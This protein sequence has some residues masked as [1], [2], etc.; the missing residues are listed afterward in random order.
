MTTNLLATIDLTSAGT[1][2]GSWAVVPGMTATVDIA[3]IDSVVVMSAQI[4]MLSESADTTGDFRFTVDGSPVGPVVPAFTDNIGGRV[5]GNTLEHAVTGLSAGSHTIAVQFIN[6]KGTAELDTARTR[7]MQVYEF[8]EGA[9]IIL[10]I[11]TTAASGNTPASWTNVAGMSGAPTIAT[12]SMLLL[13][14]NL[15]SL[16]NS[17]SANFSFAI[18]GVQVGPEQIMNAQT[19]DELN[20]LSMLWAKTGVAS[21]ART[22]SLQWK[23]NGNPFPDRALRVTGVRTIQAIQFTGADWLLLADITLTSAEQD[24]ATWGV[25]AGMTTTQ[26]PDSADSALLAIVNTSIQAFD[27]DDAT[28][29]RLAMGGSLVGA[30]LIAWDDGD[31]VTRGQLLT[32]METGHTGATVVEVQWQAVLSAANTDTFR[33][34]TTQL[35]EFKKIVAGGGAYGLGSGI[36]AAYRQAAFEGAYGTASIGPAYG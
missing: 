20:G 18:D 26:T 6:V 21:G 33:P 15:S 13:I 31:D 3:G 25:Q 2:T 22:I 14:T 10:D 36:A 19:V 32:R 17:G 11:E 23:Q 34:R 8:T 12:G 29:F 4:Q 35:L 7:S 9:E 28:E 24:P 27:M 16:S 30:Q 1:G 5:N